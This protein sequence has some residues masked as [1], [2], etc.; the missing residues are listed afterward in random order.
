MPPPSTVPFKAGRA[1]RLC[2]EAC[3]SAVSSPFTNPVRVL[4]N[5]GSAVPY[6]TDALAT[7]IERGAGV[8]KMVCC[9]GSAAP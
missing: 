7:E 5:V 4:V 3:A 8:T 1:A 6:G 2:T 9:T